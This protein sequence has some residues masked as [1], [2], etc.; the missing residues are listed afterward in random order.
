MKESAARKEKVKVCKN[1]NVSS[2]LEP[3]N[4]TDRTTIQQRRNLYRHLIVNEE[5]KVIYCQIPKV[6]CTQVKRIFQALNANYQSVNK[7]KSVDIF[8]GQKIF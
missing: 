5:H 7:V 8:G 1:S 2:V 6:V 3:L 4:L